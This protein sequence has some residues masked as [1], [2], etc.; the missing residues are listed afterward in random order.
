MASSA[1]KSAVVFKPWWFTHEEV[2]ALNRVRVFQS[3]MG[4]NWEMRDASPSN[5]I[6]AISVT[7]KDHCVTISKRMNLETNRPTFEIAVNGDKTVTAWSFS[8]AKE[9]FARA[10]QIHNQ[11]DR[12][13]E[14]FAQR[15]LEKNPNPK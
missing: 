14:L 10:V 6:D 1:F 7:C 11:A 4:H 3:T 9:R 5:D 13:W 15:L 2:C 12:V 8:G